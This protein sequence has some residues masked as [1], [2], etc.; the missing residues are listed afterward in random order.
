MSLLSHQEREKEK[1]SRSM[2]SLFH[3]HIA[4]GHPG[5]AK[6]TQNIAQYYWW[7]GMRNHIT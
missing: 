1:V 3:D 6:I 2:I 5:I 7:P 4:A